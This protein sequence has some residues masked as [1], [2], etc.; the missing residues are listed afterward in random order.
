MRHGGVVVVGV[1]TLSKAG[2]KLGHGHFDVE[3]DHVCDRVE[4]DVDDLVGK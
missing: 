4:L 2:N 3:L 1:L